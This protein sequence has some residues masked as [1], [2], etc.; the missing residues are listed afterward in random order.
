MTNEYSGKILHINLTTGQFEVEYPGE[1]FFRKFLG[2][3]ALGAYYALK[4]IPKGADALGPDNVMVVSTGV[5][6]GA[7]ISGQS[8]VCV[9]AKSPL[10]GAIGDSQAGGFWPTRS[11][12]TGFDAYV[13]TGKSEKPVYLWVDNGSFELRDAS[14]LWG[15]TTAD[16]QTAIHKELGD[17]KIEIMQIGPAGERC[18]RIAN[19]MN[20]SNRA[21][22]RTGLGA[23]MGS[24]NLKAIAVRGKLKTEVA[25]K[26]ALRELA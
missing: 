11:K 3:G 16:S 6:T 20:M 4:L 17:P 25:D 7:P 10:T 26:E 9:T 12:A 5:T 2:G 1:D 14:H 19:I 15:K 22:G 24:K 21:N 13:F 8:R 23:V 18:A